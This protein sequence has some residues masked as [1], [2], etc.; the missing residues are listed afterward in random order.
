M[1]SIAFDL[2]CF[3]RISMARFAHARMLGRC[4]VISLAEATA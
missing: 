4:G 3:P 2:A 1:A